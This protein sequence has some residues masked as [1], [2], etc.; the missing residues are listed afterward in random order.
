MAAMGRKGK[1]QR[2]EGDEMF[3]ESVENGAE[4]SVDLSLEDQLDATRAERDDAMGKYQR[5]LAD[6][7]N[8][9]RRAIQAERDARTEGGVDVV[10]RIV[11]VLDYFDMALKQD[12]DKATAA[13]IIEGVRLI[14]GELIRA[15]GEF[16]VTPLEP[17]IGEIADPTR[18]EAVGTME[19][20]EL[21]PGAVAQ[22]VQPGYRVG[23]RVI[24]AAKVMVTPSAPDEQC[25]G[26]AGE[27]NV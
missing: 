14:K 2:D 26:D 5:A 13:Q 25:S 4:E 18:H 20:D 22:V 7:Q 6:F 23:D 27:E 16:G 1:K 3:D 21:V 9:Q 24:R 19:N 10:K 15:V 8:Y 17:T 11:P 12:P